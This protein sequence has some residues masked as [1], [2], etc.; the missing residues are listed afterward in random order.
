MIKKFKVG[1][2]LCHTLLIFFVIIMLFP[3]LWMLLNSLKTT[4]E[5]TKI[6]P[7]FFPNNWMYIDNF[8]IILGKY[9]FGKFFMNSL[10][11]A[12]VKTVIVV[13]VSS[14]AGYVLAKFEFRGNK[15]IFTMIL[16]TMMIPY[17]ATLIPSYQ[18]MVWFKWINTDA[19]IFYTSF[20]SG[21]GVFMMRQF[22]MSVPDSFLEAGRLDGA[23]ELKIFHRIVMPMMLNAIG[24]LAIFT[25]LWEWDNY[26]WPYLMLTDMDKYTLPIGLAMTQGQFV[27]NYGPMFAGITISVIPVVIVYLIFQKTFIEGI[28][29]GGVKE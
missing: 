11:Y 14:I 22:A 21:F 9:N 24:A 10:Y 13:Y 1:N 19:S 12:V 26:L 6:P 15:A 5:I 18:M 17:V 29:L 3:F 23:G 20:I 25:F 2:L 4:A 28:A 8:K 27:S 16:S 7:E